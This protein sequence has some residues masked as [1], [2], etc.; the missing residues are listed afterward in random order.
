MICQY[1]G[2]YWYN[3]LFHGCYKKRKEIKHIAKYLKPDNNIIRK[4]T[5][6]E[7]LLLSSSL[8]TII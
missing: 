2:L 6:D 7:E 3:H 8:A 1:S 4:N 5:F